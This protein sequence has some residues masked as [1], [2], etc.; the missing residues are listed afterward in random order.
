MGTVSRGSR[1]DFGSTSKVLEGTK[2]LSAAGSERL[3]TYNPIKN[4]HFLYLLERPRA[5]KRC[6]C[7]N[8][9]TSPKQRSPDSDRPHGTAGYRIVTLSLLVFT[10]ANLS[11][12]GSIKRCHEWPLN[13]A[14]VPIS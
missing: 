8:S 2:I 14:V 7:Q 12:S 1:R 10:G 5:M 9:R 11:D 13:G 6:L 3:T 4:W